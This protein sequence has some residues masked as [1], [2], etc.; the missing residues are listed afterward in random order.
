MITLCWAAKGGS[1]TT[2]VTATLALA[3][4]APTLL[5]DLAGDLPV[6]LGLPDH[7][8]PGIGEWSGST[9]P[10]DRLDALRVPLTP[11]LDL[12]PRG[13]VAPAGRWDELGDHL[14]GAAQAV[15]VD[16]GTAAAPTALRGHADRT[17]LVTRGCYL[18]VRRAVAAGDVGDGIVLV[19]EP[20]RAL[21]AD[22]LEA[23]L[24]VPVVSR[25][26]L[27]PAVARAV[28]A[29]LLLAKLPGAYRREIVEAA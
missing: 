20:G 2:V 12:L 4:R 22:D 8:G 1:G 7:H 15:F 17:L 27:D 18:A 19:E 24:G 16:A 28:D 10:A 13:R 9:A 14:A 5:V 26:L 3:S 21:G 23:A 29:G 6:A 25:V 11:T